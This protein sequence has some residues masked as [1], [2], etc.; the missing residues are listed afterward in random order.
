M[1]KRATTILTLSG[2][3]LLL[4]A[5]CSESSGSE[6]GGGACTEYFN[7]LVSYTDRCGDGTTSVLA[8]TRARFE[9]ICARG[10][11]APGAT[12]LAAQL[13][14]CSKQVA[15]APCTGEFDCDVTG[16]T[17]DDGAACG[18][19][20]QC[21]G[22]A[23]N[24]E[25]GSSCGKCAQRIAIGGECTRSSRCVE[26]ASCIFGGRETGKC[27]AVKIAKVGE[28]CSSSS[29]EIVHCDTGLTCSFGSGEPTCKAP[30][31]AGSDCR[32]RSECASDLR[33]VK[34]KCAAGLPEGADCELNE[35][36]KGLA[37]SREKKCAPVVLVKVGDECDAT[38]RCDRGSCKGQSFTTGPDGTTITPGKC[39]DPLRDGAACTE[40][41]REAPDCDTFAKCVG[42]KCTLPDPAQCK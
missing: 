18:E 7:A 23:C 13:S 1:M 42:G 24:T 4:L 2:L 29:D 30:G 3:V 34:D 10:L 39:V 31:G 41:S 38:R 8:N 27:V 16:G 28:R 37:C 11:V 12:N 40:D 5:A 22:G 17:L 19:D 35:C 20:Y 25:P 33:C 26:G 9:T 6:G 14:A 15:D 36:A 21:K 32:S